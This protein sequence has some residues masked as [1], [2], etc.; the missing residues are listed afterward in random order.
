MIFNNPTRDMIPEIV[1]RVRE[2]GVEVRRIDRSIEPRSV[3]ANVSARQR[4]PR[5]FGRRG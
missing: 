4:E 5:L 1:E 3:E 2:L